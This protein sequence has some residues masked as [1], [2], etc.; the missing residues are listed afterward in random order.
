MLKPPNLYLMG[1]TGNIACGKSTVVAML[2]ELGASTIDADQVTHQVQ[3]P[4]Q[5]VYHQIVSEFGAAILTAPDGAIDRRKLGAVVFADPTALRRLERIVH[6]SVHAAIVDW[7]NQVARMPDHRA[8]TPRPIAVVDAVKLFEA[9][10]KSACDTTWVVTCTQQQQ[11]ERLMRYRGMTEA[12]ALQRVTAQPPQEE[13]MRQADVIIDNSQNLE[14]TY[15]QVV[16]AWQ[17]IRW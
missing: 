17:A 1:L 3:Q 16:T 2:K 15:D 9:G 14:S 11:I 12:E 13:R 5:Y 8:L 6:P 7:L 4:G 10:W